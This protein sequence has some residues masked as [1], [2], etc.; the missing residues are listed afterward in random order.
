MIW[1]MK[2]IGCLAFLLCL[3]LWSGNTIRGQE[4]VQQVPAA[5]TSDPSP[6]PAN[7]AT[8]AWPDILSHGSKMYS[9]LYIASGSGPH[10]TV[11]MLHGF[12]GN[13]KNLDLAFSIRR[14]GWNVLV[15]FYR[16]AW[17]SGGTFSFT[18]AVEDTQ[19]SIDFLRDS[20]NA[21]KFRIDPAH[22]VLVGHSMGGFIAAYAA[23]HEPK[24]FAAALVS[25]GNLGPGSAR[26]RTDDPQFWERWNDNASR[27]VGTTAQQLVQEADS[28]PA[29]WNYMNCV[30]LLKNRPVL[31]LEADDRNTS[32]NQEL[33]SRLRQAGDSEVTEIHM[34][35][36]HPFSDHRIA[37]QA[38][39]VNWLGIITAVRSPSQGPE[40]PT[41]RTK[42]VL[43]GT[44]TPVPDP[45]RS[46]PA[47]LIVVDDR[48]Y[49]VDF[50]PGVV[51]RAEAAALTRGITAARPGNL[52]VAFVTHLHS[53]HTA[54]YS[55]LILTGWTSGRA[56]PL[57]VY[58]PSGL[59]SMT[60]HILQAYRVDIETRTNPDAA[61]REI[62]R[63][64][65]AWKVNAH[66]I[67]AGVIYK[68]EKVTVTAFAT[69]HAMES[70]GYRFDTP[71]RT[72]VISGDTNPVDATIK[73]CNGCDVLIHEAQPLEMQ[74]K[75]PES[76]QSFVARYHTTTE[77]L[78]QLAN[79]A[80]PKLLVI[81][82]TITFPPGIAP[83][84]LLPPDASADALYVS[85][86]MLQKEISSRYSGHFAIGKDLDVY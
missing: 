33:A 8:M 9:V 31:V 59:Q 34:H 50:G 49:L 28:D 6:D 4:S 63:S 69:K 64:P 68:D 81:Y 37:M 65:D 85:P 47:T 25:P 11:L 40:K 86:E 5:V 56:V 70:Y 76:V 58:G 22:I 2:R 66:E 82:H 30:S 55:D 73:A 84:R 80:K 36:D 10:P 15:P 29:K 57:E 71:D 21:K 38:A 23:A 17:G 46:G 16:G 75:M 53:D 77:Q 12:P 62:G 18:H 27:L 32:D 48:A 26:Q 13:E 24:V 39:I 14:A 3:V 60:E 35:T 19:A 45:D 42:V 41:T 52:K 43:L 67:K 74:A 51:R 61:M 72:I 78:A 20:E 7:P 83:P 54:G 44:G 79:K 1:A